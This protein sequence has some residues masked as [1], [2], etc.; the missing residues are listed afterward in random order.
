M[1]D[2]FDFR[3]E[4]PQYGHFRYISVNSAGRGYPRDD[5]MFVNSEEVLLEVLWQ[6][7]INRHHHCQE[8]VDKDHRRSDAGSG[9]CGLW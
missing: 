1:H 9:G 7:T 2:A 3:Y 6:K 5:M 8:R 4:Y